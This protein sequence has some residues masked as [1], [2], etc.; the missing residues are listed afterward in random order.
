MRCRSGAAA[1]LSGENEGR[2]EGRR[3]EEKEGREVKY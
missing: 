2:K 3:V 1:L